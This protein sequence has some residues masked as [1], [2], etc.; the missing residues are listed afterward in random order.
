MKH[1]WLLYYEFKKG[2]DQDTILIGAYDSEEKAIL[3]QQAKEQQ[4]D[5]PWVIYFWESVNVL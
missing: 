1:V 5:S 2:I 3:A 4:N